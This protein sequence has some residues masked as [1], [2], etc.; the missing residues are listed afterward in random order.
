[1]VRW[2]SAAMDR[3]QV[4][5][6]YPTLDDMIDQD[7]PVRLFDEILEQLD[8]SA[9]E[10]EY[11]GRLGQPPIHPR[12]VAGVILYGMS[13]GIRSSRALE[14]ATINAIDMIWLTSGR[15]I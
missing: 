14:R 6:F 8:W 3:Q 9:W 10:A 2:A 1:M 12:I 4:A 11:H 7:H 15:S 5:M 13:L